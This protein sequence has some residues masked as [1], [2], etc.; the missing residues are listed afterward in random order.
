[1]VTSHGY[2]VLNADG[3]HI[4]L[5][6]ERTSIDLDG[7]VERGDGSF[8]DQSP[9][10]SRQRVLLRPIDITNAHR[11]THDSPLGRTGM[12]SGGERQPPH[13]RYPP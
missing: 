9:G 5:P 3:G 2:Y 7:N 8:V 1:M 10:F 4:N 11:N 12:G 13:A 6:A